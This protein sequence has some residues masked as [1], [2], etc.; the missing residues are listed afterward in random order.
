MFS[1]ECT[2]R[3]RKR[4]VL[5]INEPVSRTRFTNLSTNCLEGALF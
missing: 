5:S 1:I 4:V 3:T 2:G